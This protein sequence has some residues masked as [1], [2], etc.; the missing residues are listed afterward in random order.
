[1]VSIDF[2][3]N[4]NSITFSKTQNRNQKQKKKKTEEK[5]KKRASSPT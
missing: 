1:V 2:F 5:I 4:Q 3:S